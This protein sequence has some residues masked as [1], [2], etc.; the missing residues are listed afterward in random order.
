[1]APAEPYVVIPQQNP[2]AG[3]EIDPVIQHSCTATTSDPAQPEY[4]D[5]AVR[6]T[7]AVRAFGTNGITQSVCDPNFNAAMISLATAI[8]GG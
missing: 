1:M 4:G 6:I 5:P 7:Q 8:H 3:G 2:A